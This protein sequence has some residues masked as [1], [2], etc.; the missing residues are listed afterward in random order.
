MSIPEVLASRFASCRSSGA[1]NGKRAKEYP[2]ASRRGCDVTL[3][4]DWYSGKFLP[5]GNSLL[6]VNYES[7]CEAHATDNGGCVVFGR[8][9]TPTEA[10]RVALAVSAPSKRVTFAGARS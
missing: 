1:R 4:E 10:I 7:G 8:A 3:N 5:S 6:V 2:N 9:A